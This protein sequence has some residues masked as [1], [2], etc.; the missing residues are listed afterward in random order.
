MYLMNLEILQ[1]RAASIDYNK[2]RNL[3]TGVILFYFTIENK[4]LIENK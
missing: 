3:Y 4:N 1:R 2:M